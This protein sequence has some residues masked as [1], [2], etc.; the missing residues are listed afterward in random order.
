MLSCAVRVVAV[1]VMGAAASAGCSSSSEPA[2]PS[3]SAPA[4]APE[5][6]SAPPATSASLAPDAI[7][8]SPG[9]VTTKVGAPAES[10]EDDYFQACRT[11]RT[12][13]D[14]QG[15][16]PKTQIEPYLKTLQ[17]APTV[18]PGDFDKRWSELSAGQQS[19]VIVAVEAAADALCG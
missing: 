5:S 3:S 4:S 10:T 15:G 14:Q 16:D 2:S 13:M 9:G 19:A 6:A 11:A 12:W 1:I 8:V 18:G 17:S 7:A